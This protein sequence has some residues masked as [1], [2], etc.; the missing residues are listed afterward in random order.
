MNNFTSLWNWYLVM[1][2]YVMLKFSYESLPVL[3]FDSLVGFLGVLFFSC[4]K[5]LSKTRILSRH[6]L[7]MRIESIFG[8]QKCMVTY[9]D[10]SIDHH[11]ISSLLLSLKVVL[12]PIMSH[13]ISALHLISCSFQVV[14]SISFVKIIPSLL[15]TGVEQ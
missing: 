13:Q 12:N 15:E 11:A 10:P 7:L 3:I 9:Y 2:P 5:V 1:L 8:F 4:F 6:L 14:F